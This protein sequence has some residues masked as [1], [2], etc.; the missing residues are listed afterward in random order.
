[1]T[2]SGGIGT[3]SVGFQGLKKKNIGSTEESCV[4]VDEDVK[5]ILTGLKRNAVNEISLDNPLRISAEDSNKQTMDFIETEFSNTSSDMTKDNFNAMRFLLENYQN[6]KFDD[7]KSGLEHLRSNIGSKTAN[8]SDHLLKTNISSFMDAIKIM[9]DIYI[10]SKTDKKNEFSKQLEKMLKEILKSAHKIYDQ[11]LVSKDKADT[12]R[13]SIQI[14]E[15]NRSL[16]YFPQNV[17]RFLANEDYEAIIKAYKDAQVQLGKVRESR[18]F[19]Q[20]RSDIDGKV[21]QVQG[22][23][24]DK[25]NQFPSSPDEQKM[26]IDFHNTLQGFIVAESFSGRVSEK[27]VSPAWHCLEEEK[28]WLVQLMIECRDMHIADEKVSSVLKESGTMDHN[29]SVEVIGRNGKA[30][31]EATKIQAMTTLPHERNKFI[32]VSLNGCVYL[33]SFVGF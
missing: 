33:N 27:Y 22:Y 23:I 21:V 9:K 24:L 10:L 29:A 32:E 1:V 31:T 28:K 17:D 6:A 8:S 3:S 15:L 26:L 16:I 25:L 4:W 2:R 18:L 13:S 7:L 20:I 11:D 5:S 14:L 12:I 19:S 30:D